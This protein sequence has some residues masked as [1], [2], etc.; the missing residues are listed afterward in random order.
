MPNNTNFITTSFLELDNE[1]YDY[2]DFT[3][4]GHDNITWHKPAYAVYENTL[5]VSVPADYVPRILPAT[6]DE[7]K[8]DPNLSLFINSFSQALRTIDY[9]L[10]NSA[11]KTRSQTAHAVDDWVNTCEKLC[12]DC[13]LDNTWPVPA[14]YPWYLLDINRSSSIFFTFIEHECN[15]PFSIAK[16]TI[17]IATSYWESVLQDWKYLTTT[18]FIPNKAPITKCPALRGFLHKINLWDALGASPGME[19]VQNQIGRDFTNFANN[20]TK[21]ESRDLPPTLSKN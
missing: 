8:C 21:A 2:T 7:K 9:W 18:K 16:N 1:Q 17:P 4:D 19:W 5:N 3:V 11:K 15:L 10:D 20:P 14:F 6:M 12:T 13:R